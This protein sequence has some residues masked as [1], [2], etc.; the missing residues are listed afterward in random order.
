MAAFQAQSGDTASEDQMPAIAKG[1]AEG[2]LA[3][4]VVGLFVQWRINRRRRAIDQ[5]LRALPRRARKRADKLRGRVLD[6]AGDV[7]P[8]VEELADKA[9]TSI[10]GLADAARP[11]VESLA[12]VAREK[13]FDLAEVARHGAE[14]AR[15]GAGAAIERAREAA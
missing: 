5:G 6:V 12:G 3:G 8:H 2:A 13:A 15:Q 14:V 4:G 7:L 9:S 11:H 10:F 1:A